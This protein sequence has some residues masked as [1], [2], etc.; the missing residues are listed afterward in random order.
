[1]NIMKNFLLTLALVVFALAGFS[2]A[3]IQVIHNSADAALESVDIWLDE[4][5][6]LDNFKFRTASPFMDAPAGVAITIS[7]KGPDSQDP[8]NPLWSGSYN[9]TD[10]E[11]YIMVAEG[12]ITAA[13]Y[14]PAVPF[15]IAVMAGARETATAEDMTDMLTHHGSTDAPALDI[16]EVGLGL[17]QLVDNIS[18]SEFD[19]YLELSTK[20]FLFEVTEA[21]GSPVIDTYEAYFRILGYKGMA[22][23][24]LTSGFLD[25]GSNNNGPA[26]GLW[27]ALA[28]GGNLVEL[29]PNNPTARVQFIHNSA[30][31]A[32]EVVDV[33]LNGTKLIDNLEFRTASPFL[34]LP[35]DEE[36][37][38][39]VT[40][41]GSPNPD[42]PLWS[43]N[44]TLTL[45][46]KYIMVA[47]G[48]VSATGYDPAQP[49]SMEIFPQAR[50]M[51]N[52][53][54]LTD[55]LWHHGSTDAPIVDIYEVGTGAGQWVDDL[56]Y[57]DFAGYLELEP[58][59]YIVEIRDETGI[60]KLAAFKLPLET[61]GMDGFALT[62]VASGFLNPENNSGGPAL[63]LWMANAAGG[64]LVELPVY[65][66]KARIQFIHNSADEVAGIVDVWLNGS[67]WLDN[68]AFRS[69]SP[70]LD[71]PAGQEVTIAV[72]GPDS[73]DPDDPLWSHVYNFQEDKAYLLVADGII[74]ASGYDPIKPF[75]VMVF[76]NAREIANS[77]GQ[78]DV[79]IHHGSTDT[80]AIDLVEVGIG[81]GLMVDNMEYGQFAGYF[82]MAPVNYILQV[83]DET[84]MTKI[85][86]YS[87]PL[88]NMGLQGQA[89]NIIVSGFLEPGNN[90]DGPEF[91]LYLV[92]A[93]GGDFIKFPLY[94]PKARIQIIN[95]SADTSAAVMDVW[96]NQTLILDDFK[97]RSASPF[98]DVPAN[99]QFT[100]SI[101]GPNSSDP[102]NPLFAH[103]YTLVEGETY[104]FVGDG[105]I[106]ETGYNP[107]MPFDLKEYEFARE[108]SN[109]ATY[110]DI[111][112]HHGATDAPTLDLNEI[113]VGA[114]L[115]VNDL[116]Y[117]TFNNYI[118]L[119]AI[120]YLMEVR[121]ATGENL[122]GTFRMPLSNPGFE[123]SAITVV[124][125]GFIG[126]ENNSDGP[127]FG[128]WAALPEGG[129]LVE[130]IPYFPTAMIQIIHNSPDAAVSQ[131]D[132]WIN[133]TRYLDDISFRTAG[134]FSGI[135]ANQQ[136][137]M[138]VTN[139]DS[140][141]PDNPLWSQSYTL[142]EDE[143][144][145]F[146][147]DGILSPT[148]YDPAKPFGMA[149]YDGALMQAT[150][151]TITDILV[152]HGA[153]DAP[154]LD[155]IETATGAGTLVDNIS[156]GQFDGYLELEPANY[157]F[158]FTDESGATDIGFFDVNLSDMELAGRSMTLL[159]SG[160][161]DPASNSDGAAFALMG[162]LENGNVIIFTNTLGI[163]EPN[164]D[165]SGMAVF[166]NPAAT[167]FDLS[168][169]L[170]NQ[171][172]VS[173]IMTDLGGRIV[174]QADLGSLTAGLHSERIGLKGVQSGCYLI[175]LKTVSG[176]ST[177]KIIVP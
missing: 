115:I 139:A 165:I 164:P 23:T 69:A 37:T 32:V 13:G 29:P 12:I 52:M 19:G 81:L 56:S 62:V 35:A 97:F 26:F 45:D 65:D 18:Y 28:S 71:V 107:P 92:K 70:F 41:S 109:Q 34:D 174:S 125:S 14:D 132:I 25:P 47:D 135:V 120:N 113:G 160:F 140:Q 161:L 175:T 73:Q 68:L 163:D 162:V 99:E 117:G 82:G 122:F 54:N 155:L 3:R 168:F 57:T 76:P 88:A 80:P 86:A 126:P 49:F 152:H 116:A 159:A 172:K 176:K 157:S 61:M 154:A 38:I 7:V 85:A 90:S 6:L 169:I 10:G 27:V 143:N 166:P 127:A 94:D 118:E 22:L 50:E 106:S 93:S 144:Y 9:L 104:I 131:V 40:D 96:L 21:G 130:M 148:G 112:F 63:G 98:M 119:P 136:I 43:G 146:V 33:W 137:T 147:L 151:N 100:I 51:A 167:Y 111:L 39:A 170:K 149:V 91:G 5:L 8:D 55:I 95:N 46:E 24:V 72:K 128:L 60:N 102:Y 177:E 11:H 75:D 123:G 89:I 87:I 30:D 124:A 1:M 58:K 129:P 141:N 142:T 42:N 108:T 78:T 110:T 133:Q 134:S 44:F 79:L 17:G 158:K 66:P 84:G 173:V 101:K 171:D 31:A 36:I 16:N 77:S 105:I 67:L 138:S 64:D 2:Q 15:D 145:I 150:G 156:Y 20:D 53:T 74:S 48:I 103:N 114:G 83:R 121:D 153:T 4:T 59:D